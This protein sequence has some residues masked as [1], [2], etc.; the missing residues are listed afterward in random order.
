MCL[1]SKVEYIFIIELR[2]QLYDFK[3]V[4]LIFF[5]MFKPN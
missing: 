4:N 3:I 1:T 5:R 2:V